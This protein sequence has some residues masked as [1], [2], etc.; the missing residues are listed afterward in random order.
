M[1]DD[2]QNLSSAVGRAVRSAPDVPAV[3]CDGVVL[4]YAELDAH[5]DRLAR[6]LASRGVGPED[7][8]AVAVPRSIELVVALLAIVRAGAAYLPLDPDYPAERTAHMVEVARPV[9]TLGPAEVA[10][11]WGG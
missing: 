4:T 2:L 11:W 9:L 3:E 8:V 10:E 7:V 6:A 1:L 5:A